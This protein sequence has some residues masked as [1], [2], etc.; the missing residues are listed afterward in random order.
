VKI[1]YFKLSVYH[2]RYFYV[3]MFPQSKVLCCVYLSRKFALFVV[4]EKTQKTCDIM[5]NLGPMIGIAVRISLV[6][7]PCLMYH[8]LKYLLY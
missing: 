3:D 2:L 6:T 7:A 4:Q 8:K 5:M 1:G